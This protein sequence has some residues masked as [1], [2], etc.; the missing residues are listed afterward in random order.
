MIKLLRNIRKNLVFDGKTGKYFKYAIGEIVLVVIGILIALQINVWNNEK[1]DRT[2]EVKILKEI[3][4]N[5]KFDLIEIQEDIS[6]MDDINKACKYV[7]SYLK[8][9]DQPSDSLH[10]YAAILRLTPHYDPNKSGYGLLISKGIGIISNDSLRNDISVHY[11]RLYN[12]YKRYEEERI[13]FHITQSEPQ[14]LDY[15]TMQYDESFKY[16]SHFDISIEDYFRLK[17][18]SAFLKLTFAI[19]V[20]NSSVQNRAKRVETKILALIKAIDNELAIKS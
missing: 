3:G 5:L 8:N 16:Y 14:L 7:R 6:T 9:N 10:F 2:L 18:D 13:R 12:Y 11:E 4:N 20:E 1:N 15:F 19:A 17:S